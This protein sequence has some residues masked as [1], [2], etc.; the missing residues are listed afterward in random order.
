MLIS[1]FFLNKR[2]I[3]VIPI[4]LRQ[5]TEVHLNVS[6]DQVS[7]DNLLEVKAGG[8]L[9]V[10]QKLS[11]IQGDFS[12]LETLEGDLADYRIYDG[13]LSGEQLKEWSKCRATSI[14]QPPLISL[15]NGRLEKVG[16]VRFTNTTAGILCGRSFNR[17]NIFFTEKM[18]FHGG[19]SWCKKL[20]GNLVVPK[21]QFDNE[22]E[23]ASVA[24]YKDQC[25]ESWTYLYWLG[26]EADP[27]TFEWRG[28][29]DNQSLSYTN[30]LPVYQKA[31]KQYECVAAVSHNKYKWAACHCEIE[32]CVMCT[33][34]FIPRL[35]LR[36]L[37]RFTLLDVDFSF[38]RNSN[39]SLVFD[40][41]SHVQILKT[42]DTWAMRS[43]LYEDLWGE[44]IDARPGAFPLG[45]HVWK[46][47]NDK[48][49]DDQVMAG[50]SSLA[51]LE[52]NS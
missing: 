41:M 29:T 51:V 50:E 44:M 24:Q 39:Q 34:A 10:G 40:G 9:V 52:A 30:F 5:S 31:S 13:A 21:N 11:S 43:R 36:G 3:K 14:T 18:N 42:N 38:R 15:V 2:R 12:R 27:Q 6:I 20:K 1:I 46:I 4:F 26:I 32:T 47:Y 35:K 48:C 33:F 8:R 16:N 19:L 45:V 28:V 17:F 25:S 49:G 23:W 7:P 22:R 37:C